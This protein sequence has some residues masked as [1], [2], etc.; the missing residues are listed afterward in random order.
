MGRGQHQG[1]VRRG[2]GALQALTP[3]PAPSRLEIVWAR[4]LRIVSWLSGWPLGLWVGL[5]RCT[6]GGGGYV[7]VR[8]GKAL[9]TSDPGWLLPQVSCPPSCQR[10]SPW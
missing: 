4:R 6:V 7:G 8:A 5:S 1:M 9:P 10:D 3:H 2:R